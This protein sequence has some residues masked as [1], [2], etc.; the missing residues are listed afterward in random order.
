MAL[1]TYS[2]KKIKGAAHKNSD[3]DGTFKHALRVLTLEA[4]EDFS[5][6]M[7]IPYCKYCQFNF[8]GS[9]FVWYEQPFRN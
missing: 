4:N 9:A 6:L 2:V 8:G 3:V 1:F 5:T 7:P